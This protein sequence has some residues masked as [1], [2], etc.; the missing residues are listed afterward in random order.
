L[1]GDTS[2]IRVVAAVIRRGHGAAE[3]VLVCQRPLHKQHGGLWEFP[4]GKCEPGETDEEAIRRE[5]REELSVDV[6]AVASPLL[7]IADGG[8]RYD[9]V[10]LPTVI[11][12]APQC[13]EHQALEWRT[14]RSVLELPLAPSDRRFVDVQLSTADR[15]PTD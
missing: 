9:I 6:T 12:G 7:V 2:R 11:V 13:V 14:W 10:F 15:G 8:S 1:T 5:V 3:E 4:G